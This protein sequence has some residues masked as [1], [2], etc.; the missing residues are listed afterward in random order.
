MS[1]MGCDVCDE[2][3][4]HPRNDEHIMTPNCQIEPLR[5]AYNLKNPSELKGNSHMFD[6]LCEYQST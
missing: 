4:I 1:A 2:A 6:F 3:S 5:I